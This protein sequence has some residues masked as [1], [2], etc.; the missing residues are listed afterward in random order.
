MGA[1]LL[2]SHGLKY[3]LNFFFFF[4]F[5]IVLL[6]YVYCLR[7]QLEGG[8]C[9]FGVFFRV[10]IVLSTDQK[11]D[12]NI[13]HRIHLW[14]TFHTIYMTLRRCRAQSHSNK[15][16]TW[17]CHL[18]LLFTEQKITILKWKGYSWSPNPAIC[19]E[20]GFAAHSLEI[21][22]KTQNCT[23]EI[24]DSHAHKTFAKRT[25]TLE[26]RFG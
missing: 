26:G 18:L 9:G 15:S 25:L 1:H 4:F 2:T 21:L 7:N 13:L 24:R 23:P 14:K 20:T 22:K 16:H 19:S 3:K 10:F 5:G 8:R 12:W 6:C 11:F 17:V